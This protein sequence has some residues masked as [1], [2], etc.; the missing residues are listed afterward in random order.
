[1][2][3][4]AL[5][6][7]EKISRPRGEDISSRRSSLGRTANSWKSMRHLECYNGVTLGKSL[8]FLVSVSLFV[9]WG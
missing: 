7:E 4:K 8:F 6:D 1:M 3:T 2:N 9:T 5:K